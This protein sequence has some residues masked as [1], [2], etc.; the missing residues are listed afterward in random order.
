LPDQS[1]DHFVGSREQ[2]R[3]HV[4]AERPG[5][6]ELITNSRAVKGLIGGGPF[7]IVLGG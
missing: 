2:R 6:L 1:L 4:E 7:E 5:R 3:R